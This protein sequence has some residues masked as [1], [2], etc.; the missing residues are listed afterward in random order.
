GLFINE[1]EAQLRALLAAKTDVVLVDI[2][3]NGGGNDSALAMA[4]MLSGRELRAPR[5]GFVRGPRWTKEFALREADIDAGLE[6]AQGTEN[7]F[8]SGLKAKLERAQKG[9]ATPCD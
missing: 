4:R 8:L 9:A 7:A 2:A 5:M 6:T 1:F 3:D